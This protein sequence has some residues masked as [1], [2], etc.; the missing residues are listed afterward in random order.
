MSHSP[1][2]TIMANEPYR[3]LMS[4]ANADS[5]ELLII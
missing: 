2:P 3:R 4:N 5:A 1:P